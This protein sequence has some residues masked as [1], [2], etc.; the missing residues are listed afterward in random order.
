MNLLTRLPVEL[1]LAP[2]T[3]SMANQVQSFQPPANFLRTIFQDLAARSQKTIGKI[4]KVSNLH[5]RQFLFMYEPQQDLDDR[6]FDG[7]GALKPSILVL[8]SEQ[9]NCVPRQ[10]LILRE[11]AGKGAGEPACCKGNF[12][13]ID[14]IRAHFWGIFQ[15]VHQQERL[16]MVRN[17]V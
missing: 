1:N 7:V 17:F 4:R 16:K 5:F 8:R 9:L 12:W 13:D 14:S 3:V 10:F 6:A 2:G 15:P 11:A